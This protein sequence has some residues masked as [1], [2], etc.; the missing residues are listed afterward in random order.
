MD[1]SF[2]IQ[3]LAR[4]VNAWCDE[5]RIAPANGQAGDAVTER[6]IRY[7]RTLGLVDAP[8]SGEGAGFTELH[9]EQLK[10]I[11][12][13]QAQGLPLRRIRELLYGRDLE[14]LREI[15]KHGASENQQRSHPMTLPPMSDQ[16]WRMM[17]L[18]DDFI[19]VSRSGR[20]IPDAVRAQIQKLLSSTDD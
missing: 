13:L 3:E 14:E 1:E 8:V 16:L 11:R 19:L 6:N 20:Q 15:T 5:H 12:L 10:S 17:P 18:D 9:E 2:P 7:Y 4:R